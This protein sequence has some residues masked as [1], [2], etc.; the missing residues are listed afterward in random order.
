VL[1]DDFKR[2]K[3][4]DVILPFTVLRRLDCVLAPT[5]DRVL[6][7]FQELQARGLQNL[8]GQLRRAARHSFYNTSAF[9]FPRLLDDP[10][11][12]GK[13]LRAYINGFSE[14]MRDVI[15]KFKLR[16]TIDTLDEKGLVFPLIQK[17]SGADLHPD[18]VDNHTMGTI[19]EELIRRFNEQSN[20]N[21]G[22]HFTPRDVIRLMVRLLINGDRQLLSKQGVQREVFDPAC[23]SGGMLSIAKEYILARINPQATIRLFGQEVNDETYAVCKSDLLIKGDDQDADH[24]KPGSCLSGDGHS[25]RSFDY[26]ITNPPYGKDWKKEQTYIEEEAARGAAGRFGAGLP[27][28]SDGQLLFLQHMI[29]KMKPVAEGGS[30]IAIVMN[31]SPLFTG[32]AGSGESEIRR[33]ILENDWLEA[34]VALPG[35]L[36]YN[37]GI[38]TYVWVLT[39]RKSRASR[40]KVLLVNGAATRKDGDKEVEVFAR[41]MRRS[42]GDKRNELGE[43]HIAELA[44]LAQAFAEGPHA[45]V[46]DTADFGYRKITVERPL[47]LNFQ[48]SSERI[49]RLSSQ[50]AFQA[51]AQSKKKGTAGDEE[52]AEGKRKQEQIV[53]ALHRLDSATVWKDRAAFEQVLDEALEAA[54]IRVTAAVKKA[55]LA[56]LA[57]KDPTA[58]PCLNAAGAFEPDADLR[59]YESVPLKEDVRAYF[60]REVLPHVPDAWISEEPRDCD[61]KDQRPGKVGYEINFNRYFYE[62]A[63]P[64][65][66][67][68][69]QAEIKTL[70]AETLEMLQEVGR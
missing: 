23:G 62:Y 19:F 34:I 30:R 42:L 47:R 38:N 44:A 4:P 59:D 48:A 50:P 68:E 37:T 8:D 31:G 45:K 54:G 20:E 7:S 53:A 55:I 29:S 22:E 61:R 18:K 52:A 33:W 3:Y 2:G 26:M 21:P 36:F 63:P 13:N 40:R 17:F 9:D 70:E 64:R 1:R 35:Q 43:D 10:K 60:E 16:A 6:R 14:N 65:P 49:A 69:I 46:F 56:A 39:N 32:D 11:N 57:E 25:R 12:I 58:E 67:E 41:K 24:I 66:L 27:R 28:V 51:L 5:K 15:D